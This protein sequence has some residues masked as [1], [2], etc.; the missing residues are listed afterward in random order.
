[1]SAISSRSSS[2][3]Y[4]TSSVITVSSTTRSC[5]TLL[6]LRLCNIACG[7]PSR[8]AVRNTAVPGTRCGGWIA[9]DA[10]N[11]SIGIAP[12][13][14]R[15]NR[16]SRPRRQVEITVNTPAA[17][18]S[19]NQPPWRILT[20]FAAKYARSTNSRTPQMTQAGAW[21]HF[22]MRVITKNSRIVSIAIVPVTAM[23]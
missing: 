5:S 6:W 11:G 16:I 18:T 3:T 19:G 15:S 17:M 22:Q 23:P 9:I 1:M 20:E 10:R 12:G 13:R 14:R 2:G 21:P 8:P 7:T 4:G